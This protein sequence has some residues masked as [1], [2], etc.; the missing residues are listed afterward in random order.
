[1]NVDEQDA[2]RIVTE[3]G[4]TVAYFDCLQGTWTEA[5]YLKLTDTC[6]R[7]L[8]FTDGRIDVLPMPTDRHQSILQ[9]LFLACLLPSASSE[10]QYASRRC[11]CASGTADTGNRTCCWCA[12]PMIHGAPTPSGRG[13]IL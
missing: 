8:E 9:F 4:G 6:N 7:L 12:T 13:P 2:L 1:M 11:G 10:A 5:Q 3:D